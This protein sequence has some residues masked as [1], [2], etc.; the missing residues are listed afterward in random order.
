MRVMLFDRTCTRFRSF[1]VGLTHSWLVGGRLY[2]TLGR[3]DAFH[4]VSSW[5]E[6]LDWLATH[7]ELSEVQYWGHGQRGMALVDRD[8]L[9]ARALLPGHPLHARLE[10]VRDRMTPDCAWWFRTCDTLGAS[11]G[12]GFARRWTDFFERPVAGHTFIIGLWQSGLHTLQPGALPH[13]SPLEG[14]RTGTAEA[15]GGSIWSAP[16]Q[17]NTIHLLN[18][19]VPEGW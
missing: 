7:P 18:G 10:A 12:Q 5:S 8:L 6:G 9:D 19:T 16:G 2:R 17:P 13:W 11:K 14:V 3:F 1:P 4:G 15:P